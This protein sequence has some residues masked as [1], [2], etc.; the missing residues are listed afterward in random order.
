MSDYLLPCT[1]GKKLG[2]TKSQAGQTVRCACGK[3]LEVPT[4]RGLS[5]LERVGTP[6]AAPNKS[7]NNR[8]RVAFLLAIAAL[9]G[10]LTAG[11]LTIDLP[12]P[13]PEF[14]MVEVDEMTP[15]S[16]VMA[17]YEE[18][19]KGIEGAVPPIT[20]EMR[21]MEREREM[22][23]WGIRVALTAAGCA[24]IAALAVQ[25]SSGGRKR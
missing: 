14:E 24:A 16:N 9:V 13:L 3:E 11:Y 8:H 1:C 5:A 10:V 2:V 18:L 23:L 4:L 20:A 19:K 6:G 21:A 15:F 17:V 7:W 25:L 12:A 22:K